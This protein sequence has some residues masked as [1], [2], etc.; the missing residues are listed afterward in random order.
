ML[1]N[2]SMIRSCICFVLVVLVLS[3]AAQ[4]PTEDSV[5]AG[6][7]GVSTDMQIKACTQ[8]INAGGTKEARAMA[9]RNRCWAN[10]LNRDLDGAI[11][12]C[13]EA[14]RVL[15]NDRTNTWI[16]LYNRANAYERKGEYDK[17]IADYSRLLQIDPKRAN[18]L[19]SRGNA[20]REKGDYKR[21]IDDFSR[22]IGLNNNTSSVGDS[23][24]V[25]TTLA[26]RCQARALAGDFAKALDDCNEAIKLE[27]NE[28]VPRGSRGFVYLKMAKFDEAL[29]DF[30]AAVRLSPQRPFALY[31]RG[32]AKLRKGDDSGHADIA[33]AKAISPP[34]D[35]YFARSGIR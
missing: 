14:L 30:D 26:N 29:S 34:I 13:D 33:A 11:A 1:H 20:Y 5:C 10:T 3:A 7:K 8:T 22:S 9:F 6:G 25:G 24:D 17:A 28:T 15:P 32:I 23:L 27:P 35:D 31:G 19:N 2:S 21:A 16:T 4:T 12:D 18:T